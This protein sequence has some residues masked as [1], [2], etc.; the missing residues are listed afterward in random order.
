[1]A[2]L[3]PFGKVL[4]STPLILLDPEPRPRLDLIEYPTESTTPPSSVLQPPLELE[5]L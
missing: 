5:G 3:Q 1:M 2:E 4:I